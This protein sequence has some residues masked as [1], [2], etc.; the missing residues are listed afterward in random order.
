VKHN[1]CRLFFLLFL[2]NACGGDTTGERVILRTRI[3]TAP[4]SAAGFTT[5][6]GWTIRLTRAWVATGPLYYFDGASSFTFERKERRRRSSISEWL[7]PSAYA[8]PGHYAPGV[9]NGQM[10]DEY[11]IDLL[12]PETRLP[13]GSG[14]T[15][16]LRSGTFSFSPPQG[17]P[18][19]PS[20]GGQSVVVE[21]IAQ[22]DLEQVTFGLSA[23][24]A[25]IAKR[26]RDGLVPGCKFDAVEVKGTG[27]VTLGINP[28]LWFS[29]VDFSGIAPGSAESPTVI[30]AETTPYIAF[31][32]GLV[33]IGAYH[34][35]FVPD[36]K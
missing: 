17:G 26:A 32:L 10:L 25:T 1:L 33:Q 24:F 23:D 15:G 27:T 6:S 5:L 28:R 31:T 4:E 11:S 20:L 30:A 13:D 8:H 3:I 2:G 36:V 35:S 14:I 19:V 21:G 34:F 22:K 29:L 7:I 12:A 16:L 9:T 18:L